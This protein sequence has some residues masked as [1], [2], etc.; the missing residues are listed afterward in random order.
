MCGKRKN[1]KSYLLPQFN[2]AYLLVFSH[3]GIFPRKALFRNFNYMCMFLFVYSVLIPRMELW[4]QRRQSG[5]C[6]CPVAQ[7][8]PGILLHTWM[9]S[10]N[11]SQM[12]DPVIWWQMEQKF[13][14][15]WSTVSPTSFNIWNPNLLWHKTTQKWVWKFLFKLSL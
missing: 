15:V 5:D 6:V 7:A 2:Y 12:K 9:S 1:K 13:L 11:V 10:G 8:A 4:A 3:N 14:N